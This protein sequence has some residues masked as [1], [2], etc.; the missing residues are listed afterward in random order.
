MINRPKVARLWG[1]IFYLRPKIAQAII[2]P[3]R[4]IKKILK[5]QYFNILN[6]LAWRLQF[7]LEKTKKG[8]NHE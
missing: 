3:S 6:T 1:Q 5:K 2:H 7:Q 4:K 8:R